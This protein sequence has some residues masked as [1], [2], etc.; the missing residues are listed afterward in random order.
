[1][2]FLCCEYRVPAVNLTLYIF[3]PTSQGHNWG[4]ARE[5]S[6]PLDSG[7]FLHRAKTH[8]SKHQ[9]LEIPANYNRKNRIQISVTVFE[10]HNCR[11]ELSLRSGFDF[12]YCNLQGTDPEHCCFTSVSDPDP[13]GSGNFHRGDPDPN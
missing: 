10:R 9:I 11:L 2:N 5:R 1:M 3:G 8:Q 4:G 12:F 13:V 7:N 6:P